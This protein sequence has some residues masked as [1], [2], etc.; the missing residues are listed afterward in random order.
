MAAERLPAHEA[1]VEVVEVVL[2]V[3]AIEGHG[4]SHMIYI[5][6]AGN[7]ATDCSHTMYSKP[8]SQCRS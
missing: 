8:R 4:K 5:C 1:L 3:A 2:A 6:I 7:F